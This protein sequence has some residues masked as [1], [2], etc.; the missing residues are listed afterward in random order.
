MYFQNKYR[1]AMV[2]EFGCILAKTDFNYPK[3]LYIAK[4][5]Y[6]KRKKF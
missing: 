1:E 5:Q 4:E 2:L 3:M 6:L